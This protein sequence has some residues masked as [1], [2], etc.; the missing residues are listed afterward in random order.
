M[1]VLCVCVWLVCV[2]CMCVLIVYIFSRLR[3]IF[4]C[5]LHYNKLI[6]HSLFRDY[7]LFLSILYIFNILF[8]IYCALVIVPD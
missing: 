6:L 3:S 8:S 5:M 2:L 4:P 1:C 7:I